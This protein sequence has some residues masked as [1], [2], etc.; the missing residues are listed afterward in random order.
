MAGT[1]TRSLCSISCTHIILRSYDRLLTG[2]LRR[3]NM[4]D[5]DFR[6]VDHCFDYLRQSLL[7]C[8]D[9]ALEGQNNL[10][11]VPGTDGTGGTHV[12]RRYGDLWEWA[13]ERRTSNGTTL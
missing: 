1:F 7:C 12:C 10:T 6:H 4:H 11:E 2:D 13:E 3:E 9:T 8:G 5:N